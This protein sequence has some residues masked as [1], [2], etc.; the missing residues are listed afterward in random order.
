[1]KICIIGTGYVGLPTA[2]CF[3]ESG[4]QV[5]GIEIDQDR[6][7][8][9]KKGISPIYEPG[10]ADLLMRNL[11]ADRLTFSH[12]L[13]ESAPDADFYFICVGTP[14]KEDGQANLDYLWGAV[15]DI[16]SAMKKDTVIA[17]KSTVPVGTTRKVQQYIHEQLASRKNPAQAL[18]A[19]TPEFLKQGR[20]VQETFSPER[21]VFGVDEDETAQRL[22][23]LYKP[24][25]RYMD[26]ALVM[27]IESA[28][29]TKYAANAML[30][31]RISFMNEIAVMCDMLSADIEDVR[32]GIGLDKRIGPQFLY[33]GVG[34]G[35]SCFPKDVDALIT[36]ANN[37]G[38]EPL[39]LSAVK[40]RNSRH[41]KY[42]LQ[43]IERH[44]NHDISGLVFA[45]WGLAFKPDTDD[46]R[47]APSLVI[48]EA[49]LEKGAK[50]VAHDPL[51]NENAKKLM[52]KHW[53]DSGS[54]KLTDQQYSATE[55]ADA[56]I[57]VTEWKPFRTPDFMKLRDQLKKPVIFDG[58]NQFDP[59][60]IKGL[61]FKYY[62]I[63]RG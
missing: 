46:M 15:N 54:V 34:Y 7:K 20:A 10:L 6:L 53:L 37:I 25:N 23:I 22:K 19:F 11:R 9:L 38:Y 44:F 49:L 40:E 12:D 21:F 29:M 43:A 24:F 57:L 33:S 62:G 8:L 14:A 30:A 61:G 60:V 5:I 16:I 3:A 50:V 28:E 47:E 63:G 56:L 58:R 4:N 1:M 31:T 2:A 18:V 59:D 52:P 55:G 39:V 27:K 51:A 13:A 42:I 32:Y 17:I 35:G 45:V 36:M 41:K 26:R 48:I